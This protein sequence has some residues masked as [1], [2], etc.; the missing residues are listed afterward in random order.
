MGMIRLHGVAGLL[1]VV[2]LCAT[3]DAPA[4]RMALAQPPRPSPGGAGVGDRADDPRSATAAAGFSAAIVAVNPDSDFARARQALLT[5]GGAL[6][7]ELANRALGRRTP[8][9]PLDAEP[10]ELSEA[11]RG[12]WQWTLAAAAGMTGDRP[13]EIEALTALAR[14]AH[15]LAPWAALRVAEAT[16]EIDPQGADRLLASLPDQW[17]GK[18]R[19]DLCL[20]RVRAATG[21]RATATTLLR[22]LVASTPAEIGAASAAMPLAALLAESAQ[23][24]E[25]EEALALYR[26]V[27]TRAPLSRV[28]QRAASEAEALLARL[29]EARRGALAQLPFADARHRAQALA[30]ARRH[31]EA[32]A[33]FRALADRFPRR[34]AE[35]CEL[36]YA[37]GK[38]MLAR[39]DRRNG[40]THMQ[41]LVEHCR[42]AD[43]RARARYH[44]A[45]A[46]RLNG[47][48]N[49]ALATYDDLARETP[50][51]SLADDALLLGA[52]LAAD[53]GQQ[54]GA[55]TRLRT[56]TDR[57][58]SGDMRGEARFLLAYRAHRAG[59]HLAALTELDAALAEGPGERSE[60]L[61]GRAAYWRARSLEALGRRDDAT[62]AYA[63]VFVARPL[64]YYGQLA[65]ARLGTSSRQR[66]DAMLEP[67]AAGGDDG[68]LIFPRRSEMES[69]AFR[70][71]IELLAVGEVDLAKAEMADIGLTGEGADNDSLW[72]AAAL[73]HE[74]GAFRDASQLVRRRLHSV[75]TTA[76]VG[77]ARDL[78]R[79]AYPAAYAPLIETVAAREGVPP[80]FVRAVAREESGFDPRAVSAANA[81][82][83]IQLIEPTAQRFGRQLDLPVTPASLRQPEVNVPIG[84]R[85]IAF[86]RDR[87][88]QNPAVVPAAY[89]AGESA[90]DRWLR[91]TNATSFDEWVEEIPYDETRRYTRR[92][93]QSYGIYSMLD[94]HELPSLSPVLPT[95]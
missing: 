19:A 92:V 11:E 36:L 17:A 82:G 57:H 56:I 51:S 48:A 84:T 78:W 70:R 15:P 85:F 80:A 14:G 37:L 30:N 87:Y 74:A 25:R 32:E 27:A 91:E 95:R 90:A 50:D 5:G 54:D 26:R 76:P 53:Q 29:P 64:S 45:R 81:Y 20:A 65:V 43:L 73:L 67:L 58:G 2:L 77:R 24:A 8:D 63:A 66:A 89:N 31:Q 49:L 16:W 4:H 3:C 41:M 79:I 60:D 52:R 21:D 46:Q 42:D 23:G 62:D 13:A 28:G 9:Q 75:M 33:E 69:P 34:S 10:P 47:D 12:R 1:A 61:H 71:T 83:L 93:L 40:A 88:A 94:A 22:A 44:A 59:D 86:L 18:R 68:G 35:R 7:L 72:L 38:S 6:A 39:R 55:T